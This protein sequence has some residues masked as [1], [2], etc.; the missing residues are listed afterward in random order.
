LGYKILE[1]ST[2]VENSNVFQSSADGNFHSTRLGS[3]TSSR[4]FCVQRFSVPNSKA[5]N[6]LLDPEDCRIFYSIQCNSLRTPRNLLRQVLPRVAFDVLDL[7]PVFHI[8]GLPHVPT[9]TPPDTKDNPILQQHIIWI[10]ASLLLQ[11]RH[12][13]NLPPNLLSQHFLHNLRHPSLANRSPRRINNFIPNL[14]LKNHNFSRHLSTARSQSQHCLIVK[15]FGAWG[16]LMSQNSRDIKRKPLNC[17]KGG[18]NARRNYLHIPWRRNH[19][20]ILPLSVAELR[21]SKG[22]G[23]LYLLSLKN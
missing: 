7:N 14:R 3:V 23:K 6:D 16:Y 4:K 9:N 15:D 8:K 22:A 21:R 10:I 13:P 1:Y 19:N 18:I 17:P 12:S 2:Q 20:R 11:L 5:L